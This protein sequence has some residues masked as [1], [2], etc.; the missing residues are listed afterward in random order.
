MEPIKVDFTGGNGGNEK[1]SRY[2]NEGIR[3]FFAKTAAQ[4]QM[5]SQVNSTKYLEMS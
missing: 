5:A 3:L 2:R 1:A 4:D